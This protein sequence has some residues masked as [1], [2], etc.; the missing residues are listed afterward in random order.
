MR[1]FSSNARLLTLLLSVISLLG[2]TGCNGGFEGFTHTAPTIMVQPAAQAII[3]GQSATFTVVATGAAPLSYQWLKN[4]VPISGANSSTYSMPSTSMSDNGSTFAVIVTNAVGSTTS[5]T[6]ML[7]VNSGVPVASSLVPNS[8]TPPYNSQVALVPTFSGGTAVI[9]S[10]GVGSSDISS[11]A[12]SGGSYSTP[13]LTSAKTFT[14]TVTGPTGTVTST[15]VTVTPTNVTISAIAPANQTFAPAPFSFNAVAS[16]GAT[17]H[18][19][20]TASAGSFSGNVWTPPNAAGT[21]TIQAASA[22]EP[23]VLV[24]TSATISGPVITAQPV[25]QRI[26]TGG[27]TTLS[28]AANYATSIQWKLN[29][30]NIPGATNSSLVISNASSANTGNYTVTVSNG[31]GTVTSAVAT[32][33]VGSTITSNPVSLSIIISQTA[34]FS[35]AASGQSPFAYQWYQIPNGG[36]ATLIPGAI[37]GTYTTPA[38]DLTYNNSQYY[39][40]VTDSCGVSPL[41]SS[42][43]TLT[44]NSGN[45]PPTITVQP[46]N[47]TVAP[48]GTTSF[49]VTASGSPTLSYQ[50]YVIPA[51]HTTGTS[52]SGAVTSTYS[53]PS[54]STNSNNDQDVYYVKVSN[55]AGQA[56]SQHAILAVG[57]GIVISSQPQTAFVNAGESATYSVTASSSLPLTYQWYVANPGSSTFN[58]ISGA[59]SSTYSLTNS[60]SGDTGSVFKVVVSNG[61]TNSVTSGTAGL[62]VGSLFQVNNL[63]DNNWQAIGNASFIASPCSFELTP[64]TQNQHGEIVWPTLISTGDIELSFTVS[65]GSTSSTPADGFAIVLGDPSLGATPTSLGALGSGIGAQ[66]IPGFVL[67]FD[68]YHNAG[69]PPVP[70]LGVGRSETALWENPWINVNSDIPPIAVYGSVVTHNYTVDIVNGQLTVTM[71]N[72]QVFS[73]AVTVPPVA[74]FYMTASTGGSWELPIVSNLSATVSAPSN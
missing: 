51:G 67:A 57:G 7:T 11:S 3:A 60:V 13:P 39:A 59:T 63:C 34:T 68:T 49:S 65:V 74:Y 8:A 21:Y 61:V 66:G 38:V 44:V 45:A 52:I 54:S 1:K 28:V 42:S 25:S 69:D 58:A 20:W 56:V 41:T 10:T 17:N 36:S 71:D 22:D 29:G 62:F 5:V 18:L 4:G 33:L 6:F 32:V 27:V 24:T 26:C 40:T 15:T 73:G 37:S 12:T 53:V 30:T 19:N 48:G 43:A 2:I 16:G 23:S 47:Q 31:V 64:P 55:S 35:V 72:T 50:W 9:G 70:Y 46:Q 14:L